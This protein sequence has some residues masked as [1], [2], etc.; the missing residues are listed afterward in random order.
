[1]TAMPS[2]VSE[3]GH[4]PVYEIMVVLETVSMNLP[5][6]T[7]DPLA[8]SPS[9]KAPIFLSALANWITLAYPVRYFS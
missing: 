9:L 4:H 6:P 3:V 1:M 5:K 8:N 2:A 7:C